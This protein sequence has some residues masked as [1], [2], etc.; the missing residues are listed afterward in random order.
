MSHRYD[1]TNSQRAPS[2]GRVQARHGQRLAGGH[3]TGDGLFVELA[4]RAQG[5]D[6][7]P[8]TLAVGVLERLLHC[9]QFSAVHH[10]TPIYGS[11]I[12]GSGIHRSGIHGAGAPPMCR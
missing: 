1:H 10:C 12:Y 11:G 5:D 4:G 2:G 3:R 7:F 6:R 8:R 9:A